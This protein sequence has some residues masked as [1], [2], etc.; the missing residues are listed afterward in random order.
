MKNEIK[1]KKT[2]K[3]FFFSKFFLWKLF[4]FFSNHHYRH[5]INLIRSINIY[6]TFLTCLLF[7]LLSAKLS[8]KLNDFF[9]YLFNRRTVN[10]LRLLITL[11]CCIILC[12]AQLIVNTQYGP[13]RGRERVSVLNTTY[14]SFQKIPY[15][16][17]PVSL[18]FLS[19]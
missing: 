7:L 14:I 13:I 19:F 6:Q 3:T 16:E 17:A 11:F 8:L 1:I 10:M 2:K 12:K 9:E 4:L 15:M 18:K 5:L